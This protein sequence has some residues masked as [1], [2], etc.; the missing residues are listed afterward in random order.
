M[1]AKVNLVKPTVSKTISIKSKNKKIKF[2]SKV[3]IFGIY[4]YDTFKLI[5]T[6]L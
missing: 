4:I 6:F 5:K 3:N 2:Y 1:H